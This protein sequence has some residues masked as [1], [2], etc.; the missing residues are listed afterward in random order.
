MVC[1]DAFEDRGFFTLITN[2]MIISFIADLCHETS[3]AELKDEI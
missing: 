1:Y 2:Q 3:N